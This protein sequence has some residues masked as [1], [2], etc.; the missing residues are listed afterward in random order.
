MTMFTCGKCGMLNFHPGPQCVHC[1]ESRM[2][3]ATPQ[4]GTP[5]P[6]GGMPE[7][8]PGWLRYTDAWAGLTI[9]HPPEFRVCRS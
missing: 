8:P 7:V 1:G 9:A 2:S 6:S 4:S 3:R 5:G